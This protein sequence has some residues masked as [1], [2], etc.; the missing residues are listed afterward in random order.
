MR[1]VLETETQ[2]VR[3]IDSTK[4]RFWKIQSADK[5]SSWGAPTAFK[6]M[7]GDHAAPVFGQETGY[8]PRSGFSQAN[9][10][11]TKYDPKERFASGEYPTSTRVGTA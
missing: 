5:A 11:V 3:S 6:L 8:G 1:K 7:P 2:A 9:L 10:W 4:A